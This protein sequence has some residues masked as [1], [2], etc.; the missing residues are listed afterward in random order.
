ML[1]FEQNLSIKSYMAKVECFNC[2]RAT[3]VIA[4]KYRCIYCNYPLHKYVESEEKQPEEKIIKD[5]KQNESNQSIIDQLKERREQLARDRAVESKE[6]LK[7]QE[8]ENKIKK[9]ILKKE[10]L[11]KPKVEPK[12]EPKFQSEEAK[13]E[14]DA[15]K[16]FFEKKDLTIAEKLAPEAPK[17][18]NEI[19]KPVEKTT[20]NDVLKNKVQAVETVKEEVKS[21]INDLVKEIKEEPKLAPVSY[22]PPRDKTEEIVF[23]AN[24]NPE[25]DGKIVA[26]WLVVHTENKSPVAYELFQGRNF[27]GRPD[28]PHHVD[29]RIEEDRFVSREHCFIQIKKDFLHRFQYILHDGS[30][31]NGRKS[32]TNG[33]FINGEEERLT[34]EVEVFLR[35]GDTVQVGETKLAFKNAYKSSSFR[36]AAE[37]V[38]N[39]DYTKT[40]AI[41]YTPK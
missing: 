16:K 34:A 3:A 10:A 1:T 14:A 36:D 8:Q 18:I 31:T 11:Q 12:V 32:S 37:S 26:G 5:F 40:V 30:G 41:N 28:G 4:P 24:K 29:V 21:S 27:I 35:D 2:K 38:I 15:K 13:L 23:K 9:E 7:Q 6:K 19:I 33:T 22:I 39:T 20:H 17:T 25:K